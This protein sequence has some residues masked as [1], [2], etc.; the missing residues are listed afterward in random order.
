MDGWI[1]E[2][3]WHAATEHLIGE[4]WVILLT[5]EPPFQTETLVQIESESADKA[6]DVT[7]QSSA[8][9]IGREAG[10]HLPGPGEREPLVDPFTLSSS[11][12]CTL[13]HGC[14]VSVVSHIC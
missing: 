12:A 7:V 1:D 4:F 8:G 10:A 3:N 14:G 5:M 13:P 2:K 11:Q 6:S 9:A